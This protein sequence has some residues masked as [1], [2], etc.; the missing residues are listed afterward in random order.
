MDITVSPDKVGLTAIHSMAYGRPVITHDNM[1][2]QGPEVEAVIPGRTD[3]GI[4]AR[5]TARPVKL[6]SGWCSTISLRTAE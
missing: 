2:R 5:Q 1:D 6:A 3:Q 4:V